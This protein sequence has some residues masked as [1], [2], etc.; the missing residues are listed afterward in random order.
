MDYRERCHRYKLLANKRKQRIQAKHT[1]VKMFIV[2][3]LGMRFNGTVI[4]K[5]VF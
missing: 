4:G 5:T 3:M 1:K 2:E